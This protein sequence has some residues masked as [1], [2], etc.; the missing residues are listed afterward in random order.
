MPDRGKTI[1][2]LKQLA[3]DDWIL[4]FNDTDVKET[5]KAALALLKEQAG[6]EERH[7]ILVD[8]CDMMYAEL[9]E[10]AELKR[11]WLMTIADNQLAVAPVGFE[12]YDELIRKTG[13]WNGLQTAYDIINGKTAE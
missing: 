5:A 1:E 10:W 13:E 2:D 6:L 12:T 4:H 3:K 7:K 9:K 11:K 8:K